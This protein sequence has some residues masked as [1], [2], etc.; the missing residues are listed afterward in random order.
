[1]I[2]VTLF[3]T[4]LNT[5][6]NSA[7]Q[8]ST[9]QLGTMEIYR[10]VTLLCQEQ[11]SLPMSHREANSGFTLSKH[12]I[13]QLSGL[14]LRPDH[15]LMCTGV[16]AHILYHSCSFIT[17][18]TNVPLFQ[19]QRGQSPVLWCDKGARKVL[20]KHLP[21]LSYSGAIGPF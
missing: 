15:T 4:Y 19:P 21:L 8:P 13:S 12:H 18:R 17:S 7:V 3:T 14:S 5:W 2:V 16:T 1:M 6:Q 11:C 9:A 20:K 10:Q